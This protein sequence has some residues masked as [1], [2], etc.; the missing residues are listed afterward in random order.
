MF[1]RVAITGIGVVSP[2]GCGADAYWNSLKEGVSGVGPL[3]RFDPAGCVSQIAGEVRD[4][5]PDRFINR[6][7]I[8]YLSRA[9]QFALVCAHMAVDDAGLRDAPKE[10]WLISV[11]SG[12]G[13]VDLQEKESLGAGTRGAA[14]CDPLS[15]P[16]GSCASSAASLS[17]EFGIH[18]EAMT[19]S[20][21]C[22]SGLNSLAYAFRRI[23]S[24][25]ASVAIAG[26][27]ECP[28]VPSVLGVLGNGKVLSRRNSAP[29]RASRPFDRGR[30][31]Y[32]LAEGA[33][34]F[35][36]ENM[37]HA[38]ERDARIYAELAGAG[39]TSDAFSLLRL[40]ERQDFLAAAMKRAL[41]EARLN[42]DDVDEIHAHGSS[43]LAADVRE[44]RAIKDVL[45]IHARR[46]WIC[47]VKSMI[48]MALGAGGALQAAAGALS[49]YHDTAYPTIN[50]EEPDPDCDLD[51]V[52]NVARERRVGAAL[53]NSTG[54][55][56]TNVCVALR[57]ARYLSRTK[58]VRADRS[59]QHRDTPVYFA[60]RGTPT[61]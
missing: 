7:K 56:G 23:R 48:G 30:D 31:G 6:R 44:T 51:Y 54:M 45:G 61:L 9:A 19:C 57:S 17:I 22:S 50:Y 46:V 43:S 53:V 60:P 21:A 52:P 42:P 34:F 32:V 47:A 35:I 14:F 37:S 33:A 26:G 36:L 58:D 8:A 40:C 5:Q 24:G 2:I 11:G 3:T 10:D 59:F 15:A 27:T 41:Y 55:G 28:L 16:G 18:G 12:M 13:G 29:G 25:D 20:T 39:I 38:V 49:V 1:E 4:F